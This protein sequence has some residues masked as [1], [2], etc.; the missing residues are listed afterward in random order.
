MKTDLAEF[1]ST[2]THDTQ[3][4]INQASAQLKETNIV[5]STSIDFTRKFSTET[6]DNKNN[7]A[8]SSGSSSI[9]DRYLQ[10]L[11]LLQSNESTF[12]NDVTDIEEFNSWASN[13]NTD[14]YKA[15]ISDLLIENSA[16]RL[17]YS[18]LVFFKLQFLVLSIDFN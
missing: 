16:M 17:I 5:S 14:N 2:M 6:T 7:T 12:L 11:K 8:T 13:F 4:L 1:T 9:H 10:E 15:Q 3:S 18:Q